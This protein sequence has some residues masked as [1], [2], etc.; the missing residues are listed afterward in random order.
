M[1]LSKYLEFATETA[2]L[3]GRVTLGYYQS[4]VQAELKEG[5]TPVTAA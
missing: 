2:Y 3:P 4:G 5:D 1:D